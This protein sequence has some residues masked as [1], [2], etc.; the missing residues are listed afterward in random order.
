MRDQPGIV[1]AV[2][3]LL[4]S[5]WHI[6][7]I[8]AALIVV[9]WIG[10]ALAMWDLHRLAIEQQ[11]VTVRNLS[12]V[13]A[14]QTTR[15]VQLVDRE[16][17]DV[18]SRAVELSLR[19]PEDLV[20]SF[21]TTAVQALLRDRL[22]NLPQANAYVVL[23]ADAHI[24]VTTR[25]NTSERLDLSDRDYFRHFV[26]NDDHGPF[27]GELAISR[28]GGMRTLY[29]SRRIDGAGHA[30][31]GVVVGAIDL[32]FLTNF[33]RA[34]GLPSGMAVTLL[35]SD[36]RVLA[37]YPDDTHVV[38]HRVPS[39]SQWHALAAGQGGAYR[40]KGN[41]GPAHA[42]VAV[43]PLHAW[44]LVVDVAIPEPVAL[45]GWRDQATVIAVGGGAA[46]LGLAA[47][48]SVIGQQFRRKAEQNERLG[49]IAQQLRASE[50]RMLDF[51]HMAADF[52]WE[53]DGALRFSWISDSA[54]INAMQ[55]PQRLGMTPWDALGA[56]PHAPHWARLRSDMEA[57]KPFREFHDEETDKDGQLHSVSVSG[58]PLFDGTGQFIGYRGTGR[59]I[60]ADVLA[61]HE[62]EAAKEHAETANRIKSEFL[63][64]MSHE[65]RT[66]LNAVLGFS[67][68]IRDQAVD[69]NA[70][71]YATEINRAGRHL[72]DMIN[73]L[74]DLSKI[75]AGRYELSDDVVDIGRLVRSCI[76][77][78]KPRAIEGG[79]QIDNA[80]VALRVALRA[81]TRALKQIV[82][83]VLS[84]AVKFTPRE[85]MVSIGIE[86]SDAGLTLVVTDTG[87]G[88]DP[89]VRAILCQP[90]RQADASISRK[91]GG[92][93]L[94]LAIS[95]KLLAL[96][97]A[98]L[99]LDSTQGQGTTV[100][101]TFPAE[102][103]VEAVPFAPNLASALSA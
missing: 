92:T 47:L 67:E 6:W 97:G 74:L 18:Q 42:I 65:L 41:I 96:H 102:R 98:T 29:L 40:S 66:P 91:F 101:M 25:S 37:R 51:A 27:V 57:H 34:I 43:Q 36:G 77:M 33:Y 9:T 50:D 49:T 54:M 35:S 21:G 52:F 15:Y 44:P 14:E 70:S 68:L 79:V 20:R 80:T 48:F 58:I 31:L 61:A 72:L 93:G 81:D 24:V 1:A 75:E 86:R 84:N 89:S 23:D 95:Q 53:A 2:R 13:L 62:L 69:A 46:S 99:M 11:R 16:L 78:L 38:G 82:L 4:R 5:R 12:F 56:D 55:I 60:T 3:G 63:T 32:D 94:G 19:G 8:G 28:A 30:L 59:D 87:I 90:F 7:A 17:Q 76:A 22:R 73:D 83:N 26:A 10:C 103:I 64:N 39:Q 71:E 85:G 45:S 100:R 88:I